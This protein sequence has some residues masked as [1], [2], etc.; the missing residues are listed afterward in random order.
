MG[1]YPKVIHVQQSQFAGRSLTIVALSAYCLILPLAASGGDPPRASS[2]VD[3]AVSAQ[4]ASNTSA[5]QHKGTRVAS[6]RRELLNSDSR[7]VL[8]IAHRG[9]W[10]N[11]PENSLQGIRNSIAM[12]VDIV[13]M[14]VRM[15]RDGHLVLMHDK[16]LDR[17]TNGSG[18]VSEY[19][20]TE[21]KQLRLKNGQGISTRHQ[22]PTLE[23]ALQ[24]AKGNVMVN[25]D[26]CYGCV[27]EAY[28]VLERTATADHAV[29][30][31]AVD[32]GTLQRECGKYMDKV[33]FMPIVNLDQPNSETIIEEYMQSMRP[34]AFEFVFKDE[35]SLSRSDI[36]RVRVMGSRVW[37]NAMWSTLN[38]G[39]DDDLA[40]TDIE[41]SYGWIVNTGANMIQTDRPALLLRYLS[42]RDLRWESRRL[43][44]NSNMP[45]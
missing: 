3:M 30:K 19:T 40:V 1:K 25:L 41:T 44:S 4:I 20:L 7:T 9:D 17:T 27:A 22:I 13:E 11:A 34:V 28:A 16:T 42:S 43:S 24:A 33:L 21:L 15:T 12:G 23:E 32:F 38:A 18:E 10:R 35:Q 5:P 37:V 36:N 2:S 29:I 26:K 14:D 45:H 8:V 31:G 39:H 6:I